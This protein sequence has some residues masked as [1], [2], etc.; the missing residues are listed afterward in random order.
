M[1]L[2]QKKLM[3]ELPFLILCWEAA[4]SSA[5]QNSHQSKDTKATTTV[6]VTLVLIY[7]DILDVYFFQVP[8]KLFIQLLVG[9]WH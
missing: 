6:Y 2:L 1:Q 7:L 8:W 3:C 4:A 9:G 5:I